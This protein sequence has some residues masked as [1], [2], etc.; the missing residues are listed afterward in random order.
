MQSRTINILNRYRSILFAKAT[1][2]LLPAISL[3]S[4]IENSTAACPSRITVSPKSIKDTLILVAVRAFTKVGISIP[5]A[6]TLT[7]SIILAESGISYP[8]IMPF[9]KLNKLYSVPRFK[10]I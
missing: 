10:A 6:K 4:I 7:V 5:P 2:F 1:L 3:K 8:I 9:R